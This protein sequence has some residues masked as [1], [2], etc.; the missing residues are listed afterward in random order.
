M[1]IFIGQILFTLSLAYLGW[2]WFEAKVI[3]P[4]RAAAAKARKTAARVRH[5]R[6]NRARSRARA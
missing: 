4:T 1:L 5:P 3:R 6:K 2:L